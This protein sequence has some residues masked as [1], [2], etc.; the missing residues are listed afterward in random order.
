IATPTVTP[1]TEVQTP[2]AREPAAGGALPRTLT[3]I[4]Q[5]AIAVE[6]ELVQ[7][8]IGVEAARPLLQEAQEAA[9]AQMAQVLAVLREQGVAD[10]DIQ[11]ARVEVRHE[12]VPEPAGTGAGYRVTHTLQVTLRDLARAAA[13]LDAA[14]AAGASHIAGLHFRLDDQR[15][16]EM[17]AL[18][19]AL[20]DAE[21]RARQMAAY[22]GL[23]L[24]GVVQIRQLAAP[25]GEEAPAIPIAMHIPLDE[26]VLT[27]PGRVQ[28]SVQVEVVFAIRN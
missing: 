26:S 12:P 20:D 9:Q 21:A 11:T 25:A 7:V 22:Y 14:T 28:L 27:P 5:G 1:I 8:E 6:T 3:V 16:W 10:A 18:V 24:G 2:V 13:I 23:E 15:A 17:Q 4:G 19:Q